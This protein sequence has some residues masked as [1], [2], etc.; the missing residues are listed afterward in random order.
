M[1]K[2]SLGLLLSA[3]L[4]CS[5][6]AQSFNGQGKF[7]SSRQFVVP[8]QVP[9]NQQMFPMTPAQGLQAYQFPP[10]FGI[11]DERSSKIKLPK[12]I[13][14][15]K[16]NRW[17]G[18]DGKLVRSE[19]KKFSRTLKSK[20][21]PTKTEK[22]AALDKKKP[23]VQSESPL[24]HKE[25]KGKEAPVKSAPQISIGDQLQSRNLSNP[26]GSPKELS[27]EEVQKLLNQQ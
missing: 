1:Q 8:A 4:I 15:N 24:S 7:N 2:A 13:Y 20:T 9:W 18:R 17:N 19:H 10:G 6:K 22:A 3:M 27:L 25:Y 11:I 23:I 26:D 14:S 12:N 16:N 21:L 5:V